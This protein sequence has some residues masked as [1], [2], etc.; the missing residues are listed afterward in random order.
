MPGW[1]Q[2]LFLSL[3]VSAHPNALIVQFVSAFASSP[4]FVVPLLMI[5]LWI[6]GEPSK[7]GALLA[8]TGGVL[9]GLGVNQ[10][11]GALYFEPRP[12]M[13]G[14]GRTVLAHPPDNSFPSDHA[15]FIWSLGAGVIATRSARWWAAAICLYGAAVAWSRVYLGL[16]FP[17]DMIASMAVAIVSGG[18]ARLGQPLAT[19]WALPLAEGIYEAS[20]RL[21]RVPPLLMP[22]RSSGRVSGQTPS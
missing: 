4:A 19:R 7:R 2:Q 18:V 22:R 6:W 21:L 16:H 5:A 13:I 15:T 17:V 11:L 8:V 9:V 3:N 10:A 20:L 1:N 14:L 12:F